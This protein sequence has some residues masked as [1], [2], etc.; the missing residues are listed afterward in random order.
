MERKNVM[1]LN[2]NYSVR[3]TD[4]NLSN[5]LPVLGFKYKHSGI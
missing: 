1:P 5:I 2:Y 4:L 3:L